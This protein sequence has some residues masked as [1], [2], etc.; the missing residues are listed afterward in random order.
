MLEAVALTL[1]LSVPRQ[2]DSTF[3][4]M[5]ACFIVETQDSLGTG[6][7]VTT[8]LVATAS[9]VVTGSDKVVLR[10]GS[11]RGGSISGSVVFSDEHDDVA[12]IQLSSP[13]P[14]SPLAIVDTL[15]SVGEEVFTVGGPI[16]GLVASRGKVVD[17]TNESIETT[18]PV[19]HGNS[20]GPLVNGDGEVVGV[21]TQMSGGSNGNLSPVH[22]FAIPASFVAQALSSF[23]SGSHLNTPQLSVHSSSIGLV[24]IYVIAAI[25]L[26]SFIAV[27]VVSRVRRGR[28]L[29]PHIIITLD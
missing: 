9:H 23:E 4:V 21:V 25:V 11:S 6:F 2:A 14:G 18:A 28:S 24:A 19:D 26:T 29:E 8:T 20:G 27:L 17:A 7:L 1:M 12:L 5:D 22:S 13:W 10:S 15:P 3:A 16:D